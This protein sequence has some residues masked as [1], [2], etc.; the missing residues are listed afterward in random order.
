MRTGVRLT[1]F[2]PAGRSAEGMTGYGCFRPCWTRC[3][4]ADSNRGNLPRLPKKANSTAKPS[5]VRRCVDIARAWSSGVRGP[6]TAG[7][8]ELAPADGAV[9]IRASVSINVVRL[10]PSHSCGTRLPSTCHRPAQQEWHRASRRLSPALAH[11]PGRDAEPLSARITFPCKLT[12]LTTTWCTRWWSGL[13]RSE[14]E[15]QNPLRCP[16]GEIFT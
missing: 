8:G 2:A 16:P 4:T 12:R 15:L 3:S 7:H 9:S 13:C 6:D 10:T 11:P 14:G 5:R 1:R